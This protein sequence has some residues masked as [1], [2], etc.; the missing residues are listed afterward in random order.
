METIDARKYTLNSI[1]KAYNTRSWL[2]DKIVAPLEFQNHLIAVDV[3]KINSRARILEVAVGTGRSLVELAEKVGTE[4]TI[5]GV[6]LSEKMLKLTAKRMKKKGLNNFDLQ[7]AD[8]RKLP[9]PDN[10]FD[11]LYNAY[12]LD[13]IPNNELHAVINEFWRV[14]KP[15]GQLIL[16][17]M[18]KNKSALGMREKLYKS[19]PSKLVLYVGG[20]CRPVYLEPIVQELGFTNVYRIFLEGKNESEVILANKIKSV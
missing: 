10:S 16:L 20:A 18:S 6:D 11:V 3:A 8:C 4:T 17:N 9:F 13:L 12:M 7:L 19:L 2:Y 14:L 1:Q 5:Y 15:M